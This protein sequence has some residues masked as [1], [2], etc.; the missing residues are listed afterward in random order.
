MS[1]VASIHTSGQ[2]GFP[3]RPLNAKVFIESKT[4][5][6][7]CVA[8]NSTD[9]RRFTQEINE[10]TWD[11]KELDRVV[12]RCDNDLLMGNDGRNEYYRQCVDGRWNGE[13]PECGES[14]V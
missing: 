10:T 6:T 12:Y 13:T 14:R 3:G 4:S 5:D 11:N 2:C 9:Y 7:P 8:N 1:V